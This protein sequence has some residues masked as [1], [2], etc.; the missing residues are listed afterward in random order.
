MK[1]RILTAVLALSC[2]ALAA[3]A[4]V[5]AT[6][7]EV[8]YSSQTSYPAPIFYV[9]TETFGSLTATS[10]TLSGIFGSTS[11]LYGSTAHFELYINDFLVG[12]TYDVYPD[13][14]SNVVAFSFAL[15]A[16][17]LNS[18]NAGSA[19]LGVVQTSDYVIR[20][21]ETTLRIETSASVPDG[22]STVAI[23]GLAIVGLVALRRK[24]R[25]A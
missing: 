19:T 15:S 22:G 20:L 7:P 4:S 13:P 10:A 3:K 6:F 25:V 24:Y 23:F 17:A 5:I 18:L 2:A 14:Y 16:A 11:Q 9:G 8:N 12:S 1:I 21:S